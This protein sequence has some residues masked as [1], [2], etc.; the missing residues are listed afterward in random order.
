LE[1]KGRPRVLVCPM[2]WGL[3]HATR[4]VS[5][6]RKLT[7]KNAEVII[8]ADN[9]PYAFL[10]KEF[11]ELMFLRFQSYK[12]SY[13]AKGSMVFAMLLS[14]P[15][16]L[17]GIRKEHKLLEQIIKEY[18]IDIVISD[19]RY[20]LFVK[21]Q[22][23]KVKSQNF[24]AKTLRHKESQK[25]IVYTVFITH[26]VLIKCPSWLKM[27]EPVLAYITRKFISKY[28]ECWIPDLESGSQK[29]EVGSQKS[30]I[31]GI[32][33]SG[34]LSHKYTLPQNAYY[35]GLLSRFE[36]NIKT[37]EVV[38]KIDLLIILS[39]PEPQR[40]ILE[41]KIVSGFMFIRN[42]NF[43]TNEL[44]LSQSSGQV[45]GLNYKVI[46]VQG[47]A[48]KDEERK[49][50]ENIFIY[51]HLETEKLYQ[52]I[53]SSELIICRP[54]YSGI[55]DMAVMGK[56]AI[57][58]PTPGQTEQEYLAEYLY[59]KHLFYYMK[60]KDFD[61]EKAIKESENYNGIQI[62]NDDSM[63]DERIEKVLSVKC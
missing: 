62:N 15:K 6:I 54:G 49:L 53:K 47:K 38:E 35:I 8:A 27:F 42:N 7:E 4:C 24:T 9:Q 40:T 39:G 60:Q 18:N 63:L 43:N 29:S 36:S 50:S 19:N 25:S 57:F 30:E 12:I 31:T 32:N 55:M 23:S 16:I 56:K 17:R 26:Q 22:K 61:L 13:P 1:A 10:K 59:E 51:S 46:I 45:S 21:S 20:G 58:I 34:D 5:I 37:S 33:L 44:M 28:N 3:G 48:D 2:D 52:L 14:I 41:Q 11:P